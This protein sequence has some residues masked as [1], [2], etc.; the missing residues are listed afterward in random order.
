MAWFLAGTA[1][2]N[3]TRVK[4]PPPTCPSREYKGEPR[5]RGSLSHDWSRFFLAEAGASQLIDWRIE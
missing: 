3:G 1:S 4:A 5:E 2:A